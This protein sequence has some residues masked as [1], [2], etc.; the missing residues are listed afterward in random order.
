[1][2]TDKAKAIALAAKAS[3]SA[4]SQ[5]DI[6][7]AAA[8]LPVGFSVSFLEGEARPQQKSVHGSFDAFGDLEAMDE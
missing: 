4:A 7:D 6:D 1:M 3:A 8:S 2:V 5:A